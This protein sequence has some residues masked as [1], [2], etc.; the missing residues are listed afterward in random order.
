MEFPTDSIFYI[1]A[2]VAVLVAG[3]SKG[4][5][6]GGLGIVATPLI[7]LVVPVN[8][9]AAIMLPILCSMDIMGIWAYRNKWNVKLLYILVPA[10][11]MGIVIGTL[12]FEY[13]HEAYVRLII[14]AIA[15]IFSLKYFMQ[16]YRESHLTKTDILEQIKTPNTIVG[17]FWGCVAGF[18]SFVAHAGGPPIG[19]F[20]LPL[21]LDKTVYQATTVFFFTF[22]NFVKLVPYTMIGQFEGD[23]LLI[24]LVLMPMAP[25]GM[26]IGIKLHN[27]ISPDRYYK[28][29]YSLL[30]IT[31]LKLISDW[32]F[33]ILE[34]LA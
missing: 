25:I 10:S 19:A 34:V 1:A 13:V 24:S 21:K 26:Y 9:A 3:I 18:T 22:V 4:G 6:G 15:V 27:R 31:G 29:C 2:F 33:Y 30:L 8:V 12:T 20:L 17:Y 5:F 16:K 11:F 28:V 23:V 7:A 14:G 32:V